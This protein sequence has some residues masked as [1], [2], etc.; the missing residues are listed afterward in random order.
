MKVRRII[1]PQ[2][3]LKEYFDYDQ[4]TGLLSWKKK[5]SP[6][7]AVGQV[8]GTIKTDGRI[9]VVFKGQLHYGHNLIW[10]WM[11]G[12]P[13]SCLID[14]I[15]LNASNNR[16]ANL[17]EATDSQNRANTRGGYGFSGTKGVV[18]N[19]CKERPYRA[20]ICRNRQTFSIGTYA[21]IA[22]ASEAYKVAARKMYGEF[23]R[24][25]DTLLK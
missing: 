15:D 11:T 14:H 25:G 2:R 18:K 7:T 9:A 1:P 17:R 23:A 22:E 19:N 12:R 3:L 24:S 10:M 4:N 21:T 13:P 5:S 6:K 20:Q 16:W 8:A